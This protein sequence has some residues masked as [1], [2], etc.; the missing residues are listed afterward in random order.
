[1]EGY[2]KG[3]LTSY[4]RLGPIDLTSDLVRYKVSKVGPSLDP[5]RDSYSQDVR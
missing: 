2:Q 5:L 3:C 4:G 1:M